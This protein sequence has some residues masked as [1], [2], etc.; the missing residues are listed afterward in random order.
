MT[1]LFIFGAGGFA[2]EL[3]DV[4]DALGYNCVFVTS[5]PAERGA[6]RGVE[7]IIDEA[8]AVAQAGAMFAIGVADTR[9][10]RRIARR[11]ADRL[12]F[13]AL[14]HPAATFGRRQRETVAASEG[15]VVCAGARFMSGISTGRYGIYSLNTTIGHDCVIGDF[16]TIAPGANL[17]GRIEVGEGAWIGTNAAV[18]QGTSVAMLRIGVDCV[19]GSGAVVTRDCAD[20]STYVGVPARAR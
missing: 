14:I 8:E 3:A 1:T 13:P 9:V 6:W 11:Y 5:D 2:G 16:V 7:P 19:I 4:A 18:N 17:S 12:A 20:E 10:R 15:T